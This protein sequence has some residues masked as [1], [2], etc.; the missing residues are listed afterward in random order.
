MERGRRRLLDEAI[1]AKSGSVFARRIYGSERECGS[2]CILGR[3][4]KD[5]KFCLRRMGE[6][7]DDDEF[8][9][10]ESGCDD[11]FAKGSDVAQV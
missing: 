7:R 4:P 5:D 8:P 11:F 10:F 1:S 2:V 9:E 6:L 3:F